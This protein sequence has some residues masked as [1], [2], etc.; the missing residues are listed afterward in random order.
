MKSKLNRTR[1][2]ACHRLCTPL[3]IALL[4]LLSLLPC[5]AQAAA[6]PDDV[7]QAV[8]DIVRRCPTNYPDKVEGLPSADALAQASIP[9]LIGQLGSWNP[10]LRSTVAGELTR[11]DMDAVPA[12]AEALKGEHWQL[13][14]GALKALSAILRNRERNWK[15]H[16]PELGRYAEAEQRV[17]K[18][19]ADLLPLLI[20]ATRDPHPAVRMQS[21]APL[22]SVGKGNK[23]AANAF[24]ERS[25]DEDVYVAQAAMG[26]LGKHYS[27]NDLDLAKAIPV[28]RSCLR[29]PMPRGKAAIFGLIVKLDEAHQ[30]A[31]IPELLYHLDQQPDRDTMFGAGGQAEAVRILTDLKVKELL[32]RITTLMDKTMRGPGLFEPCLKAVT[33]FGADAKEILPALRIYLQ[34]LEEKLK[35][36]NA[37][38]KPGIEKRITNLRKVIN[39]VENS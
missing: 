16:Y 17:Q 10:A 35:T 39:H 7:E 15:E 21:L 29:G 36:A 14:H 9:A 4:S 13:R 8:E 33:A 2:P 32:P 27:V 20:D 1:R 24:L 5:C 3:G 28:F 18:D 11:R 12:L 38:H 34:G 19:F 23:D 30:R 31:L 22:A 6:Q 26:N 37:R 25:T